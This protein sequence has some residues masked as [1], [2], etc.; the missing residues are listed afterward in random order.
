MWINAILISIGGILWFYEFYPSVMVT[1][2]NRTIYLKCSSFFPI[3][4]YLLEQN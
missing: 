1:F 4:L 3:W 2:W